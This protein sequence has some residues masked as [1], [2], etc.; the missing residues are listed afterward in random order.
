AKVPRFQ[1]KCCSD[2]RGG[3]RSVTSTFDDHRHREL[4][5]LYRCEAEKPAIDPRVI[6]VHDHFIV[7]TDNIALVVFFDLVPCLKLARLRI[8]K[9]DDF[10]CRSG[11]AARVNARCFD[12]SK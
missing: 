5:S 7:L 2:W 3:S 6:V 11:L 4:W 1:Y 8:V 9:R 10:L 12:W